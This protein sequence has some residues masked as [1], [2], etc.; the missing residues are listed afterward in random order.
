MASHILGNNF[1]LVFIRHSSYLICAVER[2]INESYAR[3]SDSKL[4]IL[5]K[6]FNRHDI[7]LTRNLGH[8]QPGNV[9]LCVSVSRF[10]LYGI[11]GTVVKN[12]STFIVSVV[13]LHTLLG[14]YN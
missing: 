6:K 7:F 8:K 14:T 12:H 1:N 11:R 9:I 5:W 10:N 13:E 3:C 2:Y 4:P